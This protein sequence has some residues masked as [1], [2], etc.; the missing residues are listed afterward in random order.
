MYVMH[1]DRKRSITL[2]AETAS[3]KR[4]RDF[5]ERAVID[6]VDDPSEVLLM[7]SELV[8]NVVRH[9]GSEVTITVRDG[10]LV[11]IEVHNHDAATEA[12]R[13]FS[14]TVPGRP[15]NPRRAAD[16]ASCGHS[17]PGSGSM[18]TSAVARSCGSSG[19]ATRGTARMGQ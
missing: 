13:T 12:F 16:S 17:R 5:V 4:A 11:R 8:S 15:T 1:N 6:D 2:P 14:S 19:S 3:V 9:V 7:T 18:T 10:P